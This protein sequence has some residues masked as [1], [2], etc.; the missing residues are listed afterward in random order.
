MVIGVTAN[1]CF[2]DIKIAEKIHQI[3]ENKRNQIYFSNA[4]LSSINSIFYNNPSTI[5]F[6]FNP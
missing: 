6:I 1:L 2:V 3:N 5:D 4:V